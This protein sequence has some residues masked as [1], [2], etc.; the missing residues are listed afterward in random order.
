MA[1]FLEGGG[2]A[3]GF[4]ADEILS[5][6]TAALFGLD[7]SA[8]PDDVFSAIKA[9]INSTDSEL[10]SEITALANSASKIQTGSYTGTGTYGSSNPCKLTFDFV[11]TL[12][13]FTRTYY[14]SSYGW[15]NNSNTCAPLDCQILTTSYQN[16]AGPYCLRSNSAKKSSDG[17]TIY[18]YTTDSDASYQINSSGYT[19]Y[20]I[21]MG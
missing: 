17:K 5:T 12:I 15:V 20:W 6:S 14:A 11:P 16:K 4:S 8:T 7:E 1:V 21:A 10:S 18:W 2:G 3:A 19:Y 9:L 13:L